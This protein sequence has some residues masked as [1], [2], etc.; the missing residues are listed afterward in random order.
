LFVVGEVEV[1]KWP[2]RQIEELGA[3]RTGSYIELLDEISTA[4]VFV[5]NDSGPGHLAAIAGVPTVSIFT[6]TN[7]LRWKPLGPKVL[8]LREPSVEAILRAIGQ[9]G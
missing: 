6:T 7:P 5:G 8:A 3:R 1:E 2:A 4:G 9:F